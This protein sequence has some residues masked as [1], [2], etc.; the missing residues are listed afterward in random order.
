M[1]WIFIYSVLE[2]A[3]VPN[4]FQHI[5]FTKNIYMYI[6]INQFDGFLTVLHSIDL[7]W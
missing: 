4:E 1:W 6:F 5:S 3:D 2:V 7:N